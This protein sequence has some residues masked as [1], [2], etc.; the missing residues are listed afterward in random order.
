VTR[1]GQVVI[2]NGAPRSGKST[3]ARAVQARLSGTWVNLGVD[4]SRRSIPERLQP[5]IG[6]RPGGERPDLEGVVPVLYAAL[7]ESVAAHA[8]TG[9][10]V[11]VDV[12]H[13]EMYSKP[14]HI[15]QDCA[16]RLMGLPVLW[17]GVHCPIEVIWQRREDTWNQR[18]D[19]DDAQLLAAV[20]RWQ[21]AVHAHGRYDLELDTSML[22][23]V[24][25]AEVIADRLKNGPPGTAFAT[26]ADQQWHGVA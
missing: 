1:L 19:S 14:L 9:L 24:Q 13:H 23:P 10:N 20:D 26:F 5:G 7:Y 11:I 4:A 21:R 3:V 2:C 12:G 18:F 15:L 25:C 22:T 6:L 16:R 8:M 17:V